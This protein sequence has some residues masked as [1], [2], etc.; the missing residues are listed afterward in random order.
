MLPVMIASSSKGGGQGLDELYRAK[1]TV[2]GMLSGVW[3]LDPDP[4][5]NDL[6]WSGMPQLYGLNR[7]ALLRA[8]A[9]EQARVAED[10]GDLDAPVLFAL[11]PYGLGRCAVLATGETW[12]WQMRAEDVK[13]E[14]HERFWRQLVRSLVDDVPAPVVLKAGGDEPTEGKASRL[15]FLVRDKVFDKREGL[16]ASLQVTLP[17]G[18]PED[19]P[20]EESIVEAGVY[21]CEFTPTRTGLH[22]FNLAALNDKDEAVGSLE[23]AVYVQPDLREYRN[24]TYDGGFLKDLATRSG[25]EFFGLDRLA[26]LAERIPRI[27]HHGES[28]EVFPLWRFPAF[29]AA[30]VVLF[31][32]EWYLR[33]RSGQP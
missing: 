6:L 18:K 33:R 27:E 17:G 32:L 24:A 2:E 13:D 26:E 14:S 16:N 4:Q 7:F 31:S 12:Q 22:V 29:Y 30:L 19:L 11:Q 5:R 9:T 8:G 25:G 20:S 21:S 3:S 15:D 23:Q 10:G 1:P 28:L